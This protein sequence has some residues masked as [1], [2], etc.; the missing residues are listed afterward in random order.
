MNILILGMGVYMMSKVR[1]F[2]AGTA[3][4]VAV[5]APAPSSALVINLI[6]KGGVTGS[7]ADIGFKVAARYWESVLTNSATMNITVGFSD[8]GPRVLGGTST[9]LYTYVPMAT[10]Y[11]LL[12]ANGTKST[13]DTQAIA[14]LR[15]LDA[16]GG[17]N[18]LVPGYLT[19]ATRDGITA[20]Y[21]SRTAPTSAEIGN[22]IALASSNVKAL[23]NDATFGADEVDADIDF[24]STFAFDF[25]PTDGITADTYDFVGVAVHEIGHALGFLSGVEDF[26][27]SSGEGGFRTDDFWWGYAADMFRYSKPGQLDWTFGTGSYFSLDGGRTSYIDGYWS[28]GSNKGDGWQASHWKEPGIA[29]GDFRGI[30]NPY[31]CGGKMDQVEGLDLALL[32]AIGWNT[33][34]NVAR[35]PGYAFTTAQMYLAAVPEPASW[36][37]MIG[38]FGMVGAAMRRRRRATITVRYA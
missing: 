17:V 24:S 5:A 3:A 15:P 25:D 13:I 22:T 27:Y 6:D 4:I 28:T 26:D 30:M 32:D 21:D 7:A 20:G 2:L 31:I 12:G 9:S 38:G 23:L 29:C 35:N 19:P 10:Y 37:L 33:N 16:N 14:N 18:V 1:A 11:S 8:L 36:T 34:V